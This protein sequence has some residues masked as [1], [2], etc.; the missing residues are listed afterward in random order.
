MDKAKK[1]NSGSDWRVIAFVGYAI[2]ILTFGVGGGWA[3]VARLDKAVIA[4]GYVATETNRKTVEHFEGGIV[5]EILV[6]EGDRVAEGQV[7]FR[8]QKIQAEASSETVRDQLDS[9][10]ALEARL[11]GE[12]DQ[13]A[14]IGWPKEFDGRMQD[15]VLSHTLAD[16]DHE[17]EE[18]RASLKGQ[19][20]LLQSRIEQ[21]ETEIQGIDIEK[22][23]TERQGGYIAKELVGLH[24]LSA[25][26]LVAMTRVYAM[27]REQT[28]LEGN[29]GRL[30]ADRAKA[31]SSIGEIK[32]QMQQT[33]QKFQEDVATS[34]LEARQKVTELRER[35]TVAGDVLNR[36][37]IK[38]PRDGAVQNLKVFTKGQVVR[39]GEAL[40]D[41]VPSDEPLV[42]DA[43]F[44]PTDIDNVHA[45]MQAE[46]RFPA[47]HSRTVPVM[48]GTLE[49]ISK[50]RI[51][52]ELTH[53]YYF[54]GVISLNRADIPEEYKSRI[55]PGMPAEIVV[56]VGTRTVL[57][58][59]VSPLANSLRK[60][61][62]EPND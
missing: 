13:T 37:D 62:R 43:Q 57:S 10:L 31:E 34:L 45:G 12:R 7:L 14:E 40:L 5:R 26:Q 33:K 8:L 9:A 32:L 52:D 42:V 23:S 18:R 2:I 6:K 58:Y 15:P 1:L 17:F 38:A 4:P 22:D 25:K 59:L 39:S 41:I 61:F 53:Q 36:D 29:I 19:I 44:S 49:T 47:F 11:I 21:L 24:E 55:R 54:R 27:E 60:A 30:Q 51:I 50:D 35:V 48:L 46:I 16:Q 56:G 28:R 20:S 3:A